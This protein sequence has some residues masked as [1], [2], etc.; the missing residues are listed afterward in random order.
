M[1]WLLNLYETYKANS[2]Q[3]GVIS[4]KHNGQEYTLLP[5]SHTTQNAQVEVI[6]DQEGHLLRA[7]VLSK[8]ESSTLIPCTENSAS[9][10]GSVVSPYPL[11]D[12][13]IY[14]A[15]DY[16]DYVAEKKQTTHFQEYIEQL[17][18]W[19]QS[20]YATEN[21]KSI[22]RYVSKG[23]LIRDLVDQKVLAVDENGL[24]ISKWHDK[25]K[26]LYSDKP[27]I[28]SV[29]AGDQES[30]FIRFT[31]VEAEKVAIPV[32]KDTEMYASFIKF[33][34][35]KLGNNQFCYV[36]GKQK[37]STERHANKI[38]NAGDKAKLI[39]ANDTNGFTF[40][41][42]FN[43]SNEAA[44]IS[45]EVSQKAHNAL[46][47]LINRQAKIIDNRVFLV[48]G[49]EKVKVPDISE[50]SF[51]MMWGDLMADDYSQ[52]ASY[53]VAS[54]DRDTA[55]QFKRALCG[56]KHKLLTE[57]GGASSRINILLLDSATT[58][59]MAV[60]YYRDLDMEEYF[61][62]IEDW[63]SKCTWL[64]RY[65]KD[66]SGKF[67]SFEG[68][69]STRDIAF[70][71]YGSNANDKVVKGLMERMLPCMIDN[72]KL[73]LDIERSAIQRASSPQAMGN[74]EW[75]KTLSIACALLKSRLVT[76]GYDVALDQ[77]QN[78]RDYLFG[79]LL[80][81]ADIMERRV[82]KT[83]N[84]KRATNAIRYMNSFARYPERTWKTIQASLQPYQARLGV[85][86]TD[87]TKAMDEVASRIPFEKF[88]NEPLSG[89]YLLG[90]YSQRHEWYQRSKREE[91]K[92]DELE[93]TTE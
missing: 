38:R 57:L 49:N 24:L 93:E 60:L 30:V 16:N 12:K 13:L 73:P 9:R 20:P 39:S 72:R 37:P 79:R 11:H 45:Y 33:Y 80:A 29:V 58:G 27:N 54:T 23:S 74:W 85:K 22:Y 41:G 53:S 46:K 91:D 64:H 2:G 1:S 42:R 40:R 66:G 89:K 70:A 82:L 78:D 63:H 77:N 92:Q 52:Q 81:L 44:S 56:Y 76:E 4:V 26:E 18:E 87:I 15:G 31:V 86:A 50:D 59:R 65:R 17:R 14:T 36:T 67:R 5:V 6:I 88:N 84:E 34:E 90:F 83:Q 28:F 51:S 61:Q 68:A 19:A 75:E 69:P 48:W 21:V 43:E 7:E 32:W 55:E 8:G 3:V 10:A 47:W 62:R 35:Q 71:V 25:Y